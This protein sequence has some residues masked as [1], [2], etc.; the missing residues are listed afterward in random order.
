MISS[1]DTATL[2]QFLPVQSEKEHSL[3][4]NLCVDTPIKWLPLASS[5]PLCIYLELL[6]KLLS[7]K[8]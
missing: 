2:C 6:Y 5:L 3:I 7:L 4:S 8:S 1:R